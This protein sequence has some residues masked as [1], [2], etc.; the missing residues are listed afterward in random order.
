MSSFHG[1]QSSKEACHQV[2]TGPLK[3]S[4]WALVGPSLQGQVS[5]VVGLWL[6]CEGDRVS[7]K[8]SQRRVERNNG[9]WDLKGDGV[10][11]D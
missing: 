10:K 1:S 11:S 7:A 4:G 8:A 5:W 6:G 3:A 2:R 9:R